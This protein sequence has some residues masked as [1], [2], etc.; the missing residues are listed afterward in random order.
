MDREATTM[1]VREMRELLGIKK[2]DSYW[3]LKK[4]CFEIV[5]ISGKMRIVKKSFEDW[6]AGQTHY[7]KVTGE[8]P[9]KQLETEFYSAQRIGEM[10]DIKNCSVYDLIQ[11]AGL[12]TVV[13]DNRLRV[14]REVFDTW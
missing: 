5:K 10:L 4:N 2:T 12:R 14:P 6:Y 9:G 7:R 3:L 13:I 8:E 11:S 1:S